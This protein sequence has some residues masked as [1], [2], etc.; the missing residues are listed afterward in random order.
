M[1]ETSDD[2]VPILESDSELV[3]DLAGGLEGLKVAVQELNAAQPSSWRSLAA[4]VLSIGLLIAAI[5]GALGPLL[6]PQFP[7]IVSTI[8]SLLTAVFAFA[9]YASYRAL[10]ADLELRR[11]QKQLLTRAKY[12]EETGD[13]LLADAQAELKSSA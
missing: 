3:A 5:A 2:Q 7:I 11:R 1:N 10:S 8:S 6:Q 13:K 4:L 9:T 12:L